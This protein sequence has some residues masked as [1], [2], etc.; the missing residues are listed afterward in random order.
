MASLVR[1]V[2]GW[3]DLRKLAGGLSGEL[4]DPGGKPESV[5]TREALAWNFYLT[6]YVTFCRLK[7]LTR[8]VPVHG[9]EKK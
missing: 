4:R 7:Q 5:R 2:L 6:I 9:V 1:L 8:P 3:L